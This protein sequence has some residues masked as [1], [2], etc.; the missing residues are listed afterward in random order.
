MNTN[1]HKKTTR[2]QQRKEPKQERSILRLE[3][4]LKAARALIAERGIHGMRMTDLAARAGVPIGSLYQFFPEKVAIIRALHDDLTSRVEGGTQRTFTG[5]ASLADA[6]ALID[7]SI[8]LFYEAFRTDQTYL[9]IWMAAL[10]DTDLQSLNQRHLG[11]LAEILETAFTPLLPPASTIDLKARLALF[12][13][14]SGATVRH[15]LMQEPALARLLLDEWKTTV[16]K[17]LFVP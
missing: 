6:S 13:Y 11:R 2:I 3:T 8:D 4:I 17:T 7:R 12:V 1:G 9:P 16:R 10:S 14:L 5:V 15:A